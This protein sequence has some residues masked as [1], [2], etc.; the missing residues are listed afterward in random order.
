M[1]DFEGRLSEREGTR[2]LPCP[3]CGGDGLFDCDLRDGY[4]NYKDDPDAYAY[5]I[6]CR[7]CAAEGGWAKS[8]SGAQRLWN[9]RAPF[10]P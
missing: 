8:A 5:T 10:N 7:C 3:F 4:E 6:R 2:L 9:S 1:T